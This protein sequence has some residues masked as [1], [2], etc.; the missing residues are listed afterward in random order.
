MNVLDWIRE[1][2]IRF[3]GIEHLAQNPTGDRLT[4]ISDDE[5]IKRAKIREFKT[6]FSGNDSEL[7]NLY[8]DEKAYGYNKNPIY[9]RNKSEYFWAKSSMEVAIKRVHDNLAHD[10]VDTLVNVIGDFKAKSPDKD[11]D[12]RIK[13]I[14]DENSLRVLVNQQEMPLTMVCG[15]GAFKYTM[16]A[17]ISDVPIIEYYDAEFIRYIYKRKRLIGIVFIDYYKDAKGKDYVLLETRRVVHGD[18]RI[19]YNLYRLKSNSMDE[20]PLET[21]KETENLPKEGFEIEGLNDIMATPTVFFYDPLN[22]GYGR[23]IY[24]GKIGLFDDLD[25]IRSQASQTVRV[26]TPVEYYDVESMAVTRNGVPKPPSAFNRQFIAK[27]PMRDGDGN[28]R[29]KSVETTQPRLDFNSYDVA[30]EAVRNAIL[31]GLLAPATMGIDVSRKDN[32]EAQ[33]EKEKVTI[34]TRN[35]VIAR[36]EEILRDLFKKCLMLMEYMET[37]SITLKDYQI[38][39]SYDGFANPSFEN[40]LSILAGAVQSRVISPEM[41]VDKL[42]G[43]SISD[44]EKQR[45]LNYISRQFD[46]EEQMAGIGGEDGL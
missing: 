16:D 25:Q 35:N 1:R 18:S 43:D 40:E 10:I 5:E 42:Y 30:A 7:L 39:V 29:D 41:Y 23:S 12:G 31:S 38:D 8:T 46:L 20:V 27:E 3:L 21:L 15:Y 9:N 19:E 33:R 13:R 45:E 44:E 28:V 4:F 2:V 22:P 24:E 34:M 37:G 17:D 26:S 36:Q 32:A 6:W 11:V 14:I